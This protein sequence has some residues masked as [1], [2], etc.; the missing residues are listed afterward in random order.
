MDQRG[1]LTASPLRPVTPVVPCNLESH[2]IPHKVT[3]EKSPSS[4][5]ADLESDSGSSPGP[6]AGGFSGYCAPSGDR[7]QAVV[8][9]LVSDGQEA[10]EF[11]IGDMLQMMIARQLQWQ[12]Q[13]TSILC[14]LLL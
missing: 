2:T 4:Y 5:R 13:Q 9:P 8:T 10:P 3:K 6:S 11:Y 14:D 12:E 7:N 1:L